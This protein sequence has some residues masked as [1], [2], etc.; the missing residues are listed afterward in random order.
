[1]DP[2]LIVALT[3]LLLCLGLLVFMARILGAMHIQE[4]GEERRHR[5]RMAAFGQARAMAAPD[6]ARSTVKPAHAATAAT[7]PRRGARQDEEEDE[8]D[9]VVFVAS[10][11]APRSGVE[12]PRSVTVVSRT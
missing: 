4:Q 3:L 12:A 10:E 8:T 2:F 6:T 7:G 11:R 1:M 5:E 9:T